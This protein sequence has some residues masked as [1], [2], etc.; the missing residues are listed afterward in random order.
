[1][2]PT[3]GTLNPKPYLRHTDLYLG[4]PHGFKK[5]R[6]L[7]PYHSTTSTLRVREREAT[8]TYLIIYI[9]VHIHIYKD[10]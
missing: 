7:D 3:A 4:D 5:P 1:M 10:L 6:R 9:Y 8:C 2:L